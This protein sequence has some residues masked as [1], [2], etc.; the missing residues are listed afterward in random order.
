MKL[1]ID[2]CTHLTWGNARLESG[3]F[4][5]SDRY[6]GEIEPGLGICVY[7]VGR[8]DKYSVQMFGVTSPDLQR[9][10]INHV[11]KLAGSAGADN[12][13]LRRLYPYFE[14][15]DLLTLKCLALEAV[16][17][18]RRLNVQYHHAHARSG[19]GME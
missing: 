17:N 8:D 15:P 14:A 2:D 18:W 12:A 11:L 9:D 6:V 5:S 10:Y 7:I 13:Y 3:S 19:E 16:D 4:V 1:S